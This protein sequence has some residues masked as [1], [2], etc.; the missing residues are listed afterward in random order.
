MM[1]TSKLSMKAAAISSRIQRLPRMIGDYPEYRAKGL[2]EKTIKAFHDGI[3][4]KSF[5]LAPLKES[6][7]SHK[8]AAGYE[9]PDSPL[10][11]LGDEAD[12]T[13]ANML[14]VVK[15]ENRKWVVR[16]RR[17]YHQVLRPDGSVVHSRL[18]L[19]KLFQVHEYGCTINTG[20]SI[21]KLEPRPALHLAYRRI[22]N[23]AARK[24]PSAVVRKAIVKY[25]KMGDES[26]I[27]AIKKRAE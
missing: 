25:V 2:A 21:V 15:V 14:E 12:D 17:G 20:R 19:K 24:E 10:Y 9:R 1:V 22:M 18:T 16:P 27:T 13:Y 6:T 11:A 26:L 23:S 4:S 7:I 8:E 5:G 3:K